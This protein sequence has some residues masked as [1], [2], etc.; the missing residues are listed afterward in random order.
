M[1]Q[2]VEEQEPDRAVNGK[3]G[4]VMVRASDI[5]PENVSWIWPGVV[6]V[7][8]ITGLAGYPGLGKSQVAINIAATVSTGRP[9]PET[10]RTKRPV[11]LY[12]LGRGRRVGHTQTSANGC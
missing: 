7:G 10:L 4:V 2:I 11:T 3:R 1:S 8:R 9:W 12:S 6:P 5:R